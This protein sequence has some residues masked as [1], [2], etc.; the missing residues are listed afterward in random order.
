MLLLLALLQQ[1]APT[2]GD[3]IWLARTGAVPSGSAVRP[4]AWNPRDSRA[5][6]MRAI[7]LPTTCM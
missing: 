1:G 7:S 3:T 2:V 6:F 5:T 4:V